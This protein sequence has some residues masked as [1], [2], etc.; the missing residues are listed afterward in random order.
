MENQIQIII[1]GIKR[2]VLLSIVLK[3]RHSEIS[4]FRAKLLAKEVINVCKEADVEKLFKNL[5]EVTKAYPEVND[6]YIKNLQNYDRV[7]VEDGL[8]K[9]SNELKKPSFAKAM[10][11]KGGEN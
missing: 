1:K 3:L 6:V 7:F 5:Y 8:S 9:I 4:H 11:G 2:D 10:E